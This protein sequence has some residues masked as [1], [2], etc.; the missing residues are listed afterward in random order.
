MFSR[1]FWCLSEPVSSWALSYFTVYHH[2]L[3][4]LVY[5]L[6]HINTPR[7]LPLLPLRLLLVKITFWKKERM[8]KCKWTRSGC[9]RLQAVKSPYLRSCIIRFFV[10]SVNLCLSECVNNSTMKRLHI[11]IILKRGKKTAWLDLQKH[12]HTIYMHKKK[13]FGVG[14]NLWFL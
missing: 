3:Y 1:C 12:T 9:M 13:T 14:K 6:V 8:W 7:P 5:H 11:V 10:S 4:S 2:A